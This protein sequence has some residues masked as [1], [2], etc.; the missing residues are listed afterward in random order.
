MK[1]LRDHTHFPTV[2]AARST[3]LLLF[4]TAA[5]LAE[6]PNGVHIS[7]TETPNT[8]RAMWSLPATP[9]ASAAPGYC[10]FGF[11][12]GSL[13]QK[14]SIGA[15]YT[16]DAGGFTGSLYDVVME[17]VVPDS[18][19]FYKCGSEQSGFSNTFRVFTPPSSPAAEVKI[20]V[21]GDMGESHCCVCV[22]V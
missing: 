6:S 5:A 16:Y 21:W 12:S 2:M 15:P 9:V 4:L 14:S 8:L 3:L 19:Y 7:L 20:V 10:L 17:P 13:N 22:R 18:E 1:K 11:S